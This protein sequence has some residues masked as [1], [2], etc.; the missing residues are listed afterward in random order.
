[1]EKYEKLK[2]L[3]EE[4]LLSI[5]KENIALSKKAKASIPLCIKALNELKLHVNENGFIS[6]QE[7]I[8]F[9]KECKPQISAKLI[10]F[11]QIFNIESKKPVGTGKQVKKYFSN[12]LKEIN[13]FKV[14]NVNFYKYYRSEG[15]YLDE[16]FF[17]RNDFN[18]HLIL[19]PSTFNYD[20]TFNTSHDHKVAQILSNDLLTVY[21]H[22]QLNKLEGNLFAPPE[23]SPC[24]NPLKWTDNKNALI[25]LIYAL[26]AAGSFNNGKAD[27]KEIARCIEVNFDIDLGDLY[28]NFHE[29]RLRKT[30]RTKYLD[31]LKENLIKRMDTIDEKTN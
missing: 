30:S 11:I 13:D 16:K 19:E 6:R 24:P 9:F 18:L 3:L 27:V 22:D 21:L 10:F 12:F 4:Q 29:L 2:Q 23:N 5:S 20:V 1:M 28:R 15:V 14:N 7:E 8:Q 25:E 31:A 17:V 26:Q